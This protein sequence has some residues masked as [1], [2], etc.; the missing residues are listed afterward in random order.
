MKRELVIHES[1]GSTRGQVTTVDFFERPTL[2][3]PL[4][5]YW[6]NVIVGISLAEALV[7]FSLFLCG[8]IYN[9]ATR[10]YINHSFGDLMLIG[11]CALALGY[12]ILF[13]I[14]L[15]VAGLCSALLGLVFRSLRINYSNSVG[16]ASVGGCVGLLFALPLVSIEFPST[17]LLVVATV[18]GQIGGAG[19]ASRTYYQNL[20]ADAQP[21]T[22]KFGI[23]QLLILTAWLALA[24]TLL[25]RTGMTTES[26]FSVFGVWLAIQLAGL[27]VVY[28][29]RHW[30]NQ[31]QLAYRST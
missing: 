7:P 14:T 16:A 9:L 22:V 4:Q 21:L 15:P 3:D 26:Y 28:F 6:T 25:K 23:K 29:F 17:V 18:L 13:A 10:N 27:T 2:R 30:A 12:T 1:G 20:V 31:N 11:I 24:M 8:T 19:G 5:D